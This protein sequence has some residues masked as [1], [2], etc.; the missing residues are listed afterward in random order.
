[1]M[2]FSFN[3]TLSYGSSSSINVLSFLKCSWPSLFKFEVAYT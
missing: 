1:M 2:Y 3:M